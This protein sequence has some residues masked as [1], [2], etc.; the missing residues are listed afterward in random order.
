MIFKSISLYNFRQFKDVTIEFSNDP[1]KNVTFVTGE[2]TSGKST[3]IKAF[4]WCLYRDNNFEDDKLLS[5]VTKVSLAPGKE[6]IVRVEIKLNHDNKDYKISTSETYYMDKSGHVSIRA[7]ASTKIVIIPP[8]GKAEALSED[9][10]DLEI[11]DILKKELSPYFFFDGEISNIEDLV[12][13]RNLKQA[14]SDIMG[15]KKIEKLGKL[16]LQSE[17]TGV[18]QLVSKD[19]VS[20]D[21]VTLN[22]LKFRLSEYLQDIENKKN[23]L[24][25]LDVRLEELYSQ[26]DKIEK[27]IDNNKDVEKDVE[28]RKRLNS[29]VENL[30]AAINDDFAYILNSINLNHKFFPLLFS[31][32]YDSFNLKQL[33]SNSKLVTEK[34]LT[35]I[36]AKAI[37]QI[38]ERGYCICGEPILNSLNHLN[39][40]IEQKNFIAP[41]NYGK[42]VESFNNE[43]L[44][45]VNVRTNLLTNL[46]NYSQ[47]L[48][49]NLNDIETSKKAILEIE[50]RIINKPDLFKY[51]EK[52]NDLKSQIS[53]LENQ[54]SR[55]NGNVET[56]NMSI[57]RTNDE[58][59]RL[60][61]DTTVNKL[62]NLRLS[63][64]NEINRRALDYLKEKNNKV[65]LRLNQYVSET[66]E[67]MFQGDRG[68]KINEN[69]EVKTFLKK[70]GEELD[71][72]SGLK[73]VKNFS[74]VSGLIKCSKEFSN[75]KGS[76]ES[77]Y[78]GK[79]PLVMDAPFSK[80]DQENIETVSKQVPNMC[81][82]ILIFVLDKDFQISRNAMNEKV[83]KQYKIH[84]LS[85]DESI[86]KEL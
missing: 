75:Q 44:D 55:I 32:L 38:I 26:K 52:W 3:L 53:N 86:I 15:L 64:I 49:T 10:A 79:Y 34:S 77:S 51:K 29:K 56:L 6:T 50:G 41:M 54:Q 71:E 28:E 12:K 80:L 72:S 5:N 8:D 9:S 13:K 47:G 67:S 17:K 66:F 48:R 58:I 40:L 33:L 76:M 35:D 42:S 14:I 61:K 81:D 62:I 24:G 63:Y 36:N 43:Y 46:D 65:L 31:N 57:D 83:G 85:E 19:L 16:T 27:I 22:N 69:F 78:D 82:Q 45:D 60:T 21:V 70:N 25:N 20:Q 68:I 7:K 4:L 23:D 73:I 1:F 18:Y 84:K 37:D 2:I 11:N 39:H 59:K 74:F 30:R